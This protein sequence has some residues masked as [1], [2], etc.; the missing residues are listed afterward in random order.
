MANITQ[1]YVLQ[2]TASGLKEIVREIKGMRQDLA[3]LG[4]STSAAEAGL[5]KVSKGAGTLD[6]NLKGASK[7]TNNGT[8]ACS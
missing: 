4:K 5:N 2:V 6:R 8:K 7:S 3:G 1:E